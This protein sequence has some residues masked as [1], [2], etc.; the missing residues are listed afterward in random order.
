MTNEE[1]LAATKEAG[2]L[3]DSPYFTPHVNQ[4]RAIER[5][6]AIIE[7]RTI[8]RCADIAYWAD[9]SLSGT[10]IAAA[11]LKA[12]HRV[13]ELTSGNGKELSERMKL[14]AT[15]AVWRYSADQNKPVDMSDHNIQELF[16][17]IDH[18]CIGVDS[19]ANT[20]SS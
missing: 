13:A 16:A 18:L 1:I 2:L 5:F 3:T 15:N 11:I 4:L 20:E 14:L 17:L 7:K 6:A 19:P 10:D 8:E 12:E 9:K